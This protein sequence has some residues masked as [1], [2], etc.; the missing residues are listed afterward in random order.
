MA[1]Y[2]ITAPDGSRYEITAPDNATEADVLKY[3]QSQFG[4]QTPATEQVGD[5]P[6]Q[7]DPGEYERLLGQFGSGGLRTLASIGGAPIDIP[8]WAYERINAAFG[9]TIKMPR[10][11][12]GL[13]QLAGM[14]PG[15]TDPGSEE[16]RPQ[17]RA[18]EIAKTAGGAGAFVAAPHIAAR[19][20]VPQ[21]TGPP[22]VVKGVTESMAAG[23][24]PQAVATGAGSGIGAEVLRDVAPEGL[25]EEFAFAGGLFGGFAGMKGMEWLERG[26][27]GAARAVGLK[28]AQSVLR[29][30][31]NPSKAVKG[32]LREA[33]PSKEKLFETSRGIFNELRDSGVVIK[34]EKYQSLLG[35]IRREAKEK[36]FDEVLTPMSARVMTLLDETGPMG[37][38]DLIVKY[39]QAGIAAGSKDRTDA[40]IGVM[41]KNKI[42]AFMDDVTQ[43]DLF[44]PVSRVAGQQPVKNAGEK[45]RTAN[46]LWGR[47]RRAEM[48]EEAIVKAG[49]QAS[50]FENG[51]RIQMRQILNN[52]KKRQYFTPEEINLM[53]G[54]VRG[55]IGQNL[56]KLLGRFAF[57]EGQATNII[58][59]SMGAGVGGLI[60]SAIGG[61]VGGA[62]G[63]GTAAGGTYFSR[64]LSR[65]LA[66]NQAAFL[67]DV[68]RAGKDGRRI[69][70]A[71]LKHTPKAEQNAQ[72]LSELLLRPD[73][74]LKNMPSLPI[75]DEAIQIRAGRLPV[76]AAGAVVSAD[77]T[78]LEQRQA[79]P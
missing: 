54:I 45:F 79:L 11:S 41:I 25:E 26:V 44:G 33:S 64:Q 57:S 38:D 63:A 59:G 56:T 42:E 30:S 13:E 48:I 35:E 71:Y 62:I 52:K 15:V 2:E 22:T 73:L 68:I 31:E 16:A 18:E 58:G 6:I 24:I 65:R 55:S 77:E 39:R 78:D 3:A 36:G 23:T 51:I 17:T 46:A 66:Q 60:G 49:D 76:A 27:E 19:H 75:V 74:A 40:A 61:P 12:R 43:A 9:R 72:E 70:Q 5:E 37:L 8:L 28:E 10:A 29:V 32:A 67:D 47:A 69:V 53:R 21:M 4:Q 34:P 14:V 50:G 20:A 1:K 7:A